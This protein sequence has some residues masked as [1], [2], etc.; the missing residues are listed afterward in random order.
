MRDPKRRV[1]G[2]NIKR[3]AIAGR[4]DQL[5]MDDFTSGPLYDDLY[6]AG[7]RFVRDDKPR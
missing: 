7:F 4:R 5:R 6:I 1:V 3:G 2:C